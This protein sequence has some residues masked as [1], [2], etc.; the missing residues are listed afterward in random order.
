MITGREQL[1][2]LEQQLRILEDKLDSNRQAYGLN[3]G[4]GVLPS[5]RYEGLDKLTAVG[6]A[7][8]K[9]MNEEN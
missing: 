3:N 6:K 8:V 4:V 5:K 9:N 2:S 1:D 7:L